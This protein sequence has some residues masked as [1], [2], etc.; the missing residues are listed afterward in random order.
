VREQQ[1]KDHRGWKTF[2]GTRQ[3]R[4]RDHRLAS[5]THPLRAIQGAH[6]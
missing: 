5:R 3:S 6:A 1:G 2:H 4:T